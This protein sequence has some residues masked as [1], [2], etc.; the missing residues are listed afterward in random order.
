MSEAVKWLCPSCMGTVEAES[1]ASLFWAVRGHLADH[2]HRVAVDAVIRAGN[3][4]AHRDCCLGK[5]SG[6]PNLT[7]F[8][9]ALL[10]GMKVGW[11]EERP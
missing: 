3:D 4:C 6:F 8:D 1:D 10:G 2:M 7:S 9:R 11:A 5:S